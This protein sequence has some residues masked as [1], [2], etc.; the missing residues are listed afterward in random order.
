MSMLKTAEGQVGIALATAGLVYG[1][2]SFNLPGTASTHATKP[3]DINIEAGR[4]KAAITAAVAV[5]GIALITK[6]ANVYILAGGLL[7]AL[8]ICARHANTTDP[9]NG[10]MV[11]PDGGPAVKGVSA[12]QTAA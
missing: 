3:N 7:V 11:S 4:K 8:D 9:T 6:D 12:V 1:L 10:Q 5:V 2:Y